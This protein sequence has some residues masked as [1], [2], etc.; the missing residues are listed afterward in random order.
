MHLP[1]ASGQTVDPGAIGAKCARLLRLAHDERFADVAL[2]VFPLPAEPVGEFPGI[3]TAEFPGLATAADTPAAELVESYAE[4]LRAL[5]P[6][7]DAEVRAVC[8]DG[9][10]IVR[11]SGAE[12]GEG[13]INAGGYESLVCADP[14]ELHRVVS[15]VVWS[16]Y[17]E[18][19]V[20]QQRLHD[21]G[22][23]PLPI[24]AFVQPL[25]AAPP[26]RLPAPTETPLLSDAELAGI[27][28]W[29]DC[30]HTG[31]GMARLDTE[32][33]LATDHGTVSVTALTERGPDGRLV[34][35]LSFGFGF[36]S[37][38]RLEHTDNSLAW[39]TGS[40]GLTLWRGE[41]LTAVEVTDRRLVQLRPAA[42]FDP[43]PV[44][45]TLTEKSRRE[46]RQDRAARP[47]EILVAPAAVAATGFLTAVRLDDA[48]AQYLALDDAGRA[49][50]GHVLVERGSAAEHAGVMFRQYGIGVLR[51]RP[52]DL[53]EGASYV[54][55]DPWAEECWFGAGRPPAVD[56]VRART[57]AVPQGCRLLHDP[58]D[59][60]EAVRR[61]PDPAAALAPEA[62]PRLTELTALPHLS[63]SVRRRL[64]DRS[65][66]PDP[67]CHRRDGDS[68]ASP[69]FAARVGEALLALGTDPQD[70]LAAAPPQAGT[71]LRGLA[72]ARAGSA[73]RSA[74]LLPRSTR[75]LGAVPVGLLAGTGDLRPA[76]ALARLELR[77]DVPE[78]ALRRLLTA[79]AALASRDG[80][81]DGG[82]GTGAAVALLHAADALADALAALDVHTPEEREQ[83]LTGLAAAL[84]VT[85]RATDPTTGP[86]ID[87]TRAEALYRLVPRSQLPPAEVPRLLAAAADDPGFADRH[88]R[89]ERCRVALAAADPGTAPRRAAELTAAYRDYASDPTAPGT[90]APAPAPA[91]G[92]AQDDRTANDGGPDLA[93]LRLLARCDLV[94][95]YDAALKAI[96]LDLV[97]APTADRW[98]GYLGVLSEWLRLAEEFGLTPAERRAVTTF[99]SWLAHW[100]GGPP[101]T[102]YTIEENASWQRMLADA[103]GSPAAAPAN[104]HRLHNAVHQWQLARTERYPLGRAP[105]GVAAL[106]RISDRFCHGG[107]KLL[108]LGAGAFEL[109]VPL[110]L[111]KASLVFRPD[112]V[113]GEWS[114]QPG[115]VAGETGRLR[116]FRTLLELA[117]TWFPDLTF[118]SEQLLLAGTWTLRMEARSS[119]PRQRL[120][121]ELMRLALGV[122]R[123]LFDGSYDFSYVEDEEVAGLAEEF[124]HP[125]WG[126]I[127]PALVHYRLQYDD[128]H[129][130]ETLETLPLGT[131]VGMLCT[132]PELRAVAREL[133]AGGAEDALRRLDAVWAALQAEDD[134]AEWILRYNRVQQTALLTAALHPDEALRALARTDPAEPPGGAQDILA[135]ALLPRAD[136]WTAV[137]ARLPREPLDPDHGLTALVLRHAPHLAVAPENARAVARAVLA[138]PKAHRRCKQYLAHRHPD[139]LAAGGL[140]DLLVEDLE[141]V[142]YAAGPE[143]EAPL[144]RAVAA[145]GGRLRSDIRARLTESDP[146]L[147][148]GGR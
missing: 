112:R 123:T 142:P 57:T 14:A 20:A 50:V 27:T 141:V 13:N 82:T 93:V 114:E 95:S 33:V 32:W 74:E 91:H 83:V 126:R 104:P 86:A 26:H 56:T 16:G 68:V 101:A 25:L 45:E 36:A 132:D 129:Q 145:V 89:L 84:P 147:S 22:Y 103:A 64:V 76:V 38:Q 21:P 47:A 139:V 58:A 52:E 9:P 102:D 107:N 62:M 15:A 1:A 12:D 137:I 130:F 113:E 85:D 98:H 94:E 30:A 100:R 55:A 2:P 70:L 121:F 111:H 108:R 79:A 88:L 24:P 120:T 35:Q 128:S 127:V 18:R 67:D 87:P 133:A 134:P 31:F 39:L 135:S 40:P 81:G 54:L 43:E 23:R 122:F 118:R 146:T 49:G 4:F 10:W 105:S 97:D 11:S 5:R 75:A 48:W 28:A 53:P 19:S 71:Y 116:A 8:G 37:A 110:S 124:A 77:P 80:D 119:G 131:S 99:R 144:A 136:L 90:P 60:L 44:V 125:A 92:P 138:A 109:D 29:L 117:G 148:T 115:V 6:A 69:S 17:A 34:G 140:L 42:A 59:G 143:L 73:D 65:H 3:G 41:V 46:W 66:L 51:G 106:Q 7:L 72:A 61:A 78:P 96:L 63:P